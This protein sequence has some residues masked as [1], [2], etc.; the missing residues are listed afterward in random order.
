MSGANEGVVVILLAVEESDVGA[1]P[2]GLLILLLM[3]VA[4]FLLI[5]NMSAR[6]KRLPPEFP[7]SEPPEAPE[8][9]APR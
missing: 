8:D 9:P 7:D 3:L 6:I 1:G 2:F 4:T 5:R